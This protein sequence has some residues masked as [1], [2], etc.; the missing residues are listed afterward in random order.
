MDNEIIYRLPIL[1]TDDPSFREIAN[2]VHRP[3]RD[4]TKPVEFFPAQYIFNIGTGAN[5]DVSFFYADG[6]VRDRRVDNFD[7][8][9]FTEELWV[10]LKGDFY[11]MAAPCRNPKDPDEIPHPEDFHCYLVRQG[12]IFIQK[13]NI[14]HD[15]VW[16]V[17]AEVEVMLCLSGH[18]KELGADAPVDHIM[19]RFPPGHSIS[20]EEQAKG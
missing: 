16:P 5:V 6:R 13:P 4:Q 20:F 8:H 10:A 17:T 15:G 14:W 3:P 11:Y 19:K 2:K 1:S 18:R 9:L 7:R 12:D